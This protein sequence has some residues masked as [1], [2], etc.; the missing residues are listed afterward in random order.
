MTF[1][2]AITKGSK[3]NYRGIIR[4]VYVGGIALFFTFVMIN[5]KSSEY[6]YEIGMLFRIIL[7]HSVS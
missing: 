3:L 1:R 4:H 5:N 7:I 2:L 6:Q